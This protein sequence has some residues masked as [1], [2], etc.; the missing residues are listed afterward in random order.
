MMDEYK[1]SSCSECG[2]ELD[3]DEGEYDLEGNFMCFS[4]LYS[5]D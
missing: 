5:K 2:V 4:C 1:D 3:L